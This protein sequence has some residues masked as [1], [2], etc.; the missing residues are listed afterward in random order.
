MCSAI[1]RRTQSFQCNVQTLQRLANRRF[2]WWLAS[3][4]HPGKKQKYSFL[5]VEPKFDCECKSYVKSSIRCNFKTVNYFLI[6]LSRHYLYKYW[7]FILFVHSTRNKSHCFTLHFFSD[8]SKEL[9]INFIYFIGHTPG[10]S[11][12]ITCPRS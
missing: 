9:I 12:I 7:L 5:F 4:F 1:L 10:A 11:T 3:R 8:R 6:S 2:S